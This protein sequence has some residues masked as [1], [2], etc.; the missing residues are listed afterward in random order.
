MIKVNRCK[1]APTVLRFLASFLLLALLLSLFA[2][3]RGSDMPLSPGLKVIEGKPIYDEGVAMS[4][5][6]FTVT[7]GMMAYFFYD[8]GGRLMVQMEQNK[9]YDQTRSLHD[10]IYEDGL[11]WYDVIM[12]A[13][14]ERVCEMLIYC[15]AAHA[16][17]VELT[18]AQI[19]T[20]NE[21]L[22]RLAMDAAA[23]YSKTLDEYCQSLYGPLM[24]AADL[25]SVL[26][27]ELLA[28]SYSFTV[29]KTLEDGITDEMVQDALAHLS[30][31]DN[32]P[33]CNISYIAVPYV[34]GKANDAKVNEILA[35]L[36]ASPIA[37]TLSG[38]SSAGT[39]GSES[40]LIPDN[41]SIKA[42]SDWLFGAGR[43]V[44]DHGRVEEGTHTYVVL[45]TGNG[46]TY[47]EVSMRMHLYDTAYADWY[48]GWVEALDFGYNY[49][50]ID[51]Y[52]VDPK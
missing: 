23:I 1:K 26:E 17:G 32:T 31:R 41:T 10:Q 36:K 37:E 20:V 13:T 7:P 16:A 18:E 45:Y 39:V 50:I 35:A 14:L 27:C 28:N 24:S 22:T 46:M 5:D 4:T 21:E 48:N 8:Y 30:L 2:C 11:S 9:A 15:E 33:S 43:R 6:H 47:S 44:G 19:T 40:N 12:N 49:D 29:R 3:Q 25:R 52:D 42:L 38:Y 34:N 51:G